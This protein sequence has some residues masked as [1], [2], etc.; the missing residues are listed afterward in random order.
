MNY[1]EAKQKLIDELVRSVEAQEAGKIWEI[2][3]SLDQLEEEILTHNPEP[4]FDKLKIAIEFWSGW[5]DSRNHSWKFYEGIKASDWPQ[6]ARL[7][8]DDLRADR[9][10]DDG[11]IKR[12]FDY[13]NR[14]ERP[15]VLQRLA[16]LLRRKTD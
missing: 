4:E 3:G 6:L 2:D 14:V 7:I 1:R 15:G 16:G 13:R 11:R 8:V 9:E 12:H 10:P 5:I